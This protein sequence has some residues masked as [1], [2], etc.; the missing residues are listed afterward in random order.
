MKQKIHVLNVRR[1]LFF[2]V[3]KVNVL[4]LLGNFTIRNPRSVSLALLIVTHVILL[5]NVQVVAHH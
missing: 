5:E 2:Q 4:V 3:P 1:G